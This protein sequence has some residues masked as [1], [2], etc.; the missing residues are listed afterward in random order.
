MA[1]FPRQK[2]HGIGPNPDTTDMDGWLEPWMA[3]CQNHGHLAGV[4][5]LHSPVP[6]E[7]VRRSTEA[8]GWTDDWT[9]DVSSHLWLTPAH[10]CKSQSP[11]NSL[12]R[13]RPSVRR[14]VASAVT[15]PA[16]EAPTRPTPS[17][18]GF[19]RIPWTTAVTPCSFLVEV[20]RHE[21]GRSL[22]V[23]GLF[24]QKHSTLLGGDAKK[25]VQ[26]FIS[27]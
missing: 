15:N 16:R 1:T 11:T 9:S 20:V 27:H 22:L 18:L 8:F 17:G 26:A 25:L 21:I 13:V 10:L 24:C 3:P 4:S 2:I 23:A 6:G 5:T 12:G 14:R 7:E 19:P